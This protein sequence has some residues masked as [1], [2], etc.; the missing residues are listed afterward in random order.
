MKI[1]Y[2]LQLVILSAALTLTTGVKAADFNESEDLILRNE[3]GIPPEV[4]VFLEKTL[5]QIDSVQTRGGDLKNFLDLKNIVYLS[6]L[7]SVAD[8]HDLPSMELRLSNGKSYEARWIDQEGNTKATLLFPANYEVIFGLR[9]DEIEH[10]VK[11]Q[12]R[13]QG[14]TAQIKKL[15][16]TEVVSHHDSPLFKY[17]EESILEIKE[18]TDNIFLVENEETGLLPVFDNN[19]K[20]ASAINLLQGVIPEIEGYKLYINQDK[21][22]SKEEYTVDLAQWLNF[23]N[24]L[25]AKIYCGLEEERDDG[26]KLL[27]IL[28]V[29]PLGFRHMLSVILPPNFIDNKNSVL[30]GKLY[31]YIPAHNLGNLYYEKVSQ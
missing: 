9:K 24:S 26:I 2:Y 25:P 22:D 15:P 20:S 12:I 7:R 1:Y 19:F 8:I 10:K 3:P 13:R 31:T 21:Y 23:C 17:K 30:K 16:D 11:D 27:V 5:Q 14:K 18:M 6:D 28:D 4:F 29:Y